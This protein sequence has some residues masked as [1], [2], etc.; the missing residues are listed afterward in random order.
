M[1][2]D[3]LPGERD[4]PW[5]RRPFK[6][7]GV[8]EFIRDPDNPFTGMRATGRVL[9]LRCGGNGQNVRPADA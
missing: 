5:C 1:S 8:L 9:C 4:C 2:T 7:M 3:V 6:G